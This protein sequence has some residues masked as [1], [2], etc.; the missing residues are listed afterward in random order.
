MEELTR[1]GMKNSLTVPSLANKYFNNL[2]D[3]ND[4]PISTYNNEFVRQFVT[5]SMM[6]GRCSALNQ[7]YKSK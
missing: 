5:Q 4:E 2:R 7:Y 3:E 1:F 6:G